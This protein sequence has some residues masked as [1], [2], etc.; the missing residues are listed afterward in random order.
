MLE[1]RV[2]TNRCFFALIPPGDIARA[3]GGIRN[4]HPELTSIVA[5]DRL[6]MT[7]AI[8]GDHAVFPQD[9]S[10]ALIELARTIGVAPFEIELDRADT[11]SGSTALRPSHIPRALRELSRQLVAG[12]S[13]LGAMRPTWAFKPHVTLGYRDSESDQRKMDGIRWLC[14]EFSLIHSEVGATKHN[15]LGRWPLSARQGA[16][17]F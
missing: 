9:L 17:D 13:H 7:L 12:V 1:S 8:T 14:S 4:D 10:A 2:I 15:L 5:N 16:F 11:R 3:I 6:H